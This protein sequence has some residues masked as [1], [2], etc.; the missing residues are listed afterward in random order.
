MDYE[1]LNASQRRAYQAAVSQTHHRRVELHVVRPDGSVK[2]TFINSFLGGQVDTD[3]DSTPAQTL[4]SVQLFDPD[5]VLDW[6]NGA[7]RKY[8]A[9]VI[10][11]RFIPALDEWVDCTVFTGPLWDFSRKGPIASLTAQGSE[12]L[13][14][15][16]VRRTYSRERKA[17]AT[18]V[19]R[20]LLNKAGVPK[21]LQRV[22]NLKA[23]L[24]ESVTVRVKITDKR[25]NKPPKISHV[26]RLKLNREDTYFDEAAEIAEALDRRLVTDGKGR[27][28]VRKDPT[29]AALTITDHQLVEPPEVSR[30]GN[31]DLRNVFI[32]RGADPKGPKPQIR[33]E[34]RFPAQHAL[35]AETLRPWPGA[36]PY[37]LIETI[38]NDKL[39]T[40]K[41]AKEIAVR[42]RNRAAREL[43]QYS[44]AMLPVAPWLQLGQIVLVRGRDPLP[45]V[46]ARQMSLP[47]GQSADPQTVGSLRR[48]SAP[49]KSRRLSGGGSV[50]RGR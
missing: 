15:G 4:S 9:R 14:M 12:R 37:E 13:A 36:P 28:I 27:F 38:E 16:S 43:V 1:T 5:R 31:A 33:A 6:E 21:R 25:K 32:V 17:K 30:V 47:L 41:N 20:D 34:A 22:P 49:S 42:K 8:R 23:R 40:T 2:H 19:I 24:P 35:S 10:D 29:K 18:V 44:V 7:H 11:C 48:G 45:G 39:S 46:R 26:R 50:R 3:E